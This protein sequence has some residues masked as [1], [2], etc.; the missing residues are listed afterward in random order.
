MPTPPEDGAR[1]MRGWRENAARVDRAMETGPPTRGSEETDQHG[2]PPAT[3]TSAAA[4]S[5]AVVSGR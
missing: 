1:L 4:R 2:R 5:P 3:I